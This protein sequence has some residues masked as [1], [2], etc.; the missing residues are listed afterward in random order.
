VTPA[1]L[2]PRARRDLLDAARWIAA[3]DPKAARAFRDSVAR[4]ADRIGEHPDSGAA[5]PDIAAAPFRFWFLTGFRYVIVYHA[6]RRPPL[7]LRVLHGSR[8]LAVVLGRR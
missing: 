7:I 3:D 2:A 5:R 4:A 6:E 1:Q 8:D